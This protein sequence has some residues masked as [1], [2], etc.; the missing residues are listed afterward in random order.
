MSFLEAKVTFAFFQSS[1]IVLHCHN[2]SKIIEWLC[3]DISS[4]GAHRCIL[5]GHTDFLIANLFKCSLTWSFPTEAKSTSLQTFPLVSK[6]WDSRRQILPIKTEAKK[7]LNTSSFSMF[8]LVFLWLVIYLQKPF[9]FLNTHL[10]I[11][12]QSHS[13]SYL[14][15]I[16]LLSPLTHTEAW[17]K[18]RFKKSTK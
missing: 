16:P 7:A 15:Y 5:W 1:R 17:V 14:F 8:S 9:L 3:Y 4:L 13:Q 12:V 6:A 2:L 10:K 11:E 18:F